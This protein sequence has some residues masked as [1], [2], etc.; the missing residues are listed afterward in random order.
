MPSV[1]VEAGFLSNPG[2]REQLKSKAYQ[3]K[4]AASIYQ[5]ILRLYTENPK[6]KE[7]SPE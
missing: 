5:G 3:D 7:P 1:L 4:I 2:E 6:L